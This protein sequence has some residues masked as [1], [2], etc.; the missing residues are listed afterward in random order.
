[1]KKVQYSVYRYRGKECDT[2]HA[3]TFK[4]FADVIA[5]M[6]AEDKPGYIVMVESK[7]F[8]KPKKT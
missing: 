4:E 7:E 3:T 5:F 6:A 1:M 2:Y 8:A